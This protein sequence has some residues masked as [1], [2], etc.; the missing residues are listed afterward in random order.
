[1]I[2][3]RKTRHLTPALTAALILMVVGIL[4]TLGTY[5]TLAAESAATDC[6]VAL[7]GADEAALPAVLACKDGAACDSDGMTGNGSCK[8]KVRAVANKPATGCTPQ[9]IKSIKVTPKRLGI[10]VA[11]PSG[12]ASAVG[13]FVDV[14]LALK[15][16]NKDKPSK[17]KNIKALAKA[18]AKKTKDIDKS[19]IQ[20]VKCDQASC[21]PTT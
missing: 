18:V 16:K 19:K 15:G 10:T 2:T 4:T 1:M 5:V 3:M 6:L 11:V 17:K 7:Q 8:I 9:P 12:S 20:C 14:T 21:V 13:A